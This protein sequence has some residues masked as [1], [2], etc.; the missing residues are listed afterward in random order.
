MLWSGA[1]ID[2]EV[3]IAPL[4]VVVIDQIPAASV[5][6]Q[7]VT[8]KIPDLL[9]MIL[10]SV[11]SA[12]LTNFSCTDPSEMKYK[13]LAEKQYGSKRSKRAKDFCFAKTQGF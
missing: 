11:L 6:F 12:I 7:L 8:V 1:G 3:Q 4:L 13:L 9:A 10:D 5:L 2:L